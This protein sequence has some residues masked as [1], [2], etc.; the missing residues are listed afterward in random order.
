MTAMKYPVQTIAAIGLIIASAVLFT[1]HVS[2]TGVDWQLGGQ[3]L[4]LL[5]TAVGYLYF[6]SQMARSGQPQATPLPP[7]LRT[8]N[9]V[10][11]LVFGVFGAWI[12]WQLLSQSQITLPMVVALGMLALIVGFFL[13]RS[14]P[15]RNVPR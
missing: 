2:A 14:F 3:P 15:P 7:E 6:L 5:I 11:A 1:Q 13:L 8:V 4:V 12:G 9:R 10:I